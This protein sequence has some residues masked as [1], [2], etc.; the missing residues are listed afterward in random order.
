LHQFF[1]CKNILKGSSLIKITLFL[2][3]KNIIQKQKKHLISKTKKT[4]LISKKTALFYAIK[5]LGQTVLSMNLKY[6]INYS[7]VYKKSSFSCI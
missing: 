6:L 5:I 7:L 3:E 2:K 4:Y 1:S